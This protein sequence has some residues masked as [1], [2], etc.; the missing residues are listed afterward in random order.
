MQQDKNVKIK[1]V[2]IVRDKETQRVI[3][4]KTQRN[5]TYTAPNNA[6]AFLLKRDVTRMISKLKK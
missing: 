6:A 1:T 4:L 5:S 3:D 2:L